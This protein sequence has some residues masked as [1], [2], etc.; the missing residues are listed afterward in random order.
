MPKTAIS[1]AFHDNYYYVAYTV[2]LAVVRHSV[3]W[4]PTRL[5]GS[6]SSGGIVSCMGNVS[7][8]FHSPSSTALV[9]QWLVWDVANVL[10]GVRFPAD[11]IIRQFLLPE[12]IAIDSIV[13]AV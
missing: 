9:V 2:V 13:L 4:S 8:V 10:I 3:R 12:F 1:G 5:D 11:T 7:F 6:A